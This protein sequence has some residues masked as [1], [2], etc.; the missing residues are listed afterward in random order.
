MKKQIQEFQ[1]QIQELLE[2][3]APDTDWA[4]VREELLTRIGFYQ[5]ERLIHLIV[6]VLF[7]ILE[8]LV[9]C[10]SVITESWGVMLFG[11]ALLVLLVPYIGHYYFLE[12][13][14]QKMY[15]EYA[16]IKER[17]DACNRREM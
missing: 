4:G 5:H 14:V 15:L 2:K 17:L 3:N 9:I 8:V 16:E 7:A 11:A 10:T 13:E 1:R 12:N 6:T